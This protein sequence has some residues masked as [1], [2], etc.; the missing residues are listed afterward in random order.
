[1]GLN[2]F[3]LTCEKD[4]EELRKDIKYYKNMTSR[5]KKEKQELSKENQ[6]LKQKYINAVADYEK[7]RFEKEQLKKQLEDKTEDYKRM[8]DN[9]DSKVDVL[10]KIETQQKEFINY[11]EKEIVDCKVGSG[12]QYYAQ[13]H[14]KMFKEIIGVSDENNKQ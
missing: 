12:Q 1:M 7:T 13:E 14:L 8:K 9:F 2:N 4:N 10:T 6:K 5:L 11:L 3:I